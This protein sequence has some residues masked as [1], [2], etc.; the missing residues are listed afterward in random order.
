M[1]AP[2]S[3]LVA[4]KKETNVVDILKDWLAGGVAAGVSKTAVA[5][6]ERVKLLIQT[7]D[8]NPD[9]ISGK[10]ARYTGIVNCFTRVAA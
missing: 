3:F 5:P 6:I 2:T 7:Q 10:V 8:A 1:M 4:A 9:I